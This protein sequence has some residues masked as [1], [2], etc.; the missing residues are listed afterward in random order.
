M[1]I[2]PST[3]M[4]LPILLGNESSTT[5][6]GGAPDV[7]MP[8][9][10]ESDFEADIV[11]VHR[12]STPVTFQVAPNPVHANPSQYTTGFD[13]GQ[14]HAQTSTGL[15]LPS[16]SLIDGSGQAWAPTVASE[17]LAASN[18]NLHGWSPV[19]GQKATEGFDVHDIMMQP[20]KTAD[21]FVISN[22][23]SFLAANPMRINQIIEPATR[24]IPGTDQK[25]AGYKVRLYNSKAPTVTVGGTTMR[26]TSFGDD[27]SGIQ[28][29]RWKGEQE[30]VFVTAAELELWH[31]D[32]HAAQ[33]P[34]KTMSLIEKA[35]AQMKGPGFLETGAAS[36]AAFMLTGQQSFMIGTLMDGAGGDLSDLH[37]FPD[38]DKAAFVNDVIN[39]S[40]TITAAT[41]GEFLAKSKSDASFL[42]WPN[43]FYPSPRENEPGLEKHSFAVLGATKDGVLIGNPWGHGVPGETTG[44]SKNGIA[45]ISWDQFEAQFQTIQVT[46]PDLA[47]GLNHQPPMN[48]FGEEAL[49]M[50]TFLVKQMPET[51][52]TAEQLVEGATHGTEKE[53]ARYLA[54]A[55]EQLRQIA[56]ITGHTELPGFLD[57]AYTTKGSISITT[58]SLTNRW[59]LKHGG[60]KAYK[61]DS[62]HGH[63]LAST[64]T[65][66]HTPNDARDVIAS[67]DVLSD[68]GAP[69][70]GEAGPQNYNQQ[71]SLM[72]AVQVLHGSEVMGSGA[73][74]KQLTQDL[75]T[76]FR[77]RFYPD[78]PAFF[79]LN[80]TSAHP[81]SSQTAS[82]LES[83]P[84]GKPEVDV[85]GIG[86][87]DLGHGFVALDALLHEKSPLVGNL[88]AVT[89]TYVG[90]LI[91]GMLA[92]LNINAGGDANRQDILGD[93]LGFEMYKAFQTLGGDA[94]LSQIVEAGMEGLRTSPFVRGDFLNDVVKFGQSVDGQAVVSQLS[95]PA[96]AAFNRLPN[97]LDPS[98]FTSRDA[99]TSDWKLVLDDVQGKI[100]RREPGWDNDG[101]RSLI[102]EVRRSLVVTGV[103]RTSQS[104]FPT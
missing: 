6:S 29:T 63:Q 102:K 66:I 95:D 51:G 13:N 54:A 16:I 72:S 60:G 62:Q 47:P 28:T 46:S 84:K 24:D 65:Q 27:I 90:D 1:T 19:A 89:Y 40:G 35:I 91:Q 44:Q 9:S 4:L 22:V 79:P 99:V 73:N 61:P 26:V 15:Q 70:R 87:V 8:T 50:A 78:H 101:V 56:L 103:A 11:I 3:T 31:E 86:T 34:D 104:T 5:G 59:N 30:E 33:T 23:A 93:Q 12:G 100:D 88:K 85:P 83:V 69:P 41:H 7:W 64:P 25:E 21:C 76:G 53:R 10:G 67:L 92:P 43:G 82:L 32:H 36:E 39:R 74:A 18:T 68:P 37:N 71:L 55:L 80:Y 52:N 58:D 94:T 45:F 97:V 14:T 20:K 49:A 75:V 38:A 57:E 42:K 81:L 17:G 98:S 2:K 77:R 48:L 96:R